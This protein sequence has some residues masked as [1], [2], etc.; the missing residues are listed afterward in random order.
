MASISR[1]K[2]A[3]LTRNRHKRLFRKSHYGK[4]ERSRSDTP[5]QWPTRNSAD[6]SKPLSI[7]P[8]VRPAVV[9]RFNWALIEA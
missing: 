1:I 9:H 5:G 4:F 2:D 3:S 8:V 6:G 7:L